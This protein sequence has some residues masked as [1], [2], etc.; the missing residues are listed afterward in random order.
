MITMLRVEQLE[1]RRLLAC[2][3]SGSSTLTIVGDAGDNEIRI[4][5]SGDDQLIILCDG[6]ETV[7]EANRL[8]VRSGDGADV[9]DHW[10]ESDLVSA[11]TILY[12]LG[13]G[14]DLLFADFSGYGDFTLFERF[15]VNATG[16]A[17]DDGLYVG[18]GNVD[19]SASVTINGLD[20]RDWILTA[21]DGDLFGRMTSRMLGGSGDDEICFCSSSALGW[22]QF[23]SGRLTVSIDGGYGNDIVEADLEG[24][25]IEARVRLSI[26]GGAGNDDVLFYGSISDWSTYERGLIVNMSGDS[27]DDR[28]VVALDDDAGLGFRLSASGGLG[29]DSGYVGTSFEPILLGAVQSSLETE[30]PDW[31]L[32]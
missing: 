21:L 26:R 13:A 22:D 15:S 9:I 2:T 1:S 10:L 19:D 27:G 12:D 25:V 28:V 14:D 5:D 24:A 29:T 30:L 3:L 6:T 11:R 17:G 20:G 31:W 7:R 16:G 32:P 23:F 18:L 8:V 4:I